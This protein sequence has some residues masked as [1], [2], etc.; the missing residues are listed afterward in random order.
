MDGATCS[1]CGSMGMVRV[2]KS[3]GT[4][5]R[6]RLS[7]GD[8]PSSGSGFRPQLAFQVVG[9]LPAV[10]AAVLDE[11]FVGPRAGN[12]HACYINA[13]HIALQRYW[14]AN[15]PALLTRQ[16]NAHA[17]QKVVVGMVANQGQDKIIVQPNGPARSNHDC[18]VD[19]DF[20]H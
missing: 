2:T 19:S 11:D 12:N 1:G 3:E 7:S 6:L 15:W 18:I 8:L 16:F 4:K 9:D 10:E 17:A 20:L 5:I 14:V 13:G